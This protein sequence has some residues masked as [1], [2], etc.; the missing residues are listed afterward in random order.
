[1]LLPFRHGP[2]AAL[3]SG[4]ASSPGW[5][6]RREPGCPQLQEH[7]AGASP[8]AEPVLCAG[9]GCR[10]DG[11]VPRCWERTASLRGLDCP[12]GESHGPGTSGDLPEGDSSLGGKGE[13][14]VAR[15]WWRGL[16]SLPIGAAGGSPRMAM[17]QGAVRLMHTERGGLW[18]CGGPQ[19]KLETLPLPAAAARCRSSLG[20]RSRGLWLGWLLLGRKSRQSC[21]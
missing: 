8:T 1:M 13:Q 10:G 20:R 16:S 14:P 11:S 7:R 17:E 2:P 19:G 5:G 18:L 21:A 15:S 4:G 6:A 9:S 12:S 3:W